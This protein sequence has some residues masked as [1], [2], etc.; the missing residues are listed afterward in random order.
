MGGVVL[1]EAG[2]Q[3]EHP[4]RKSFIAHNFGRPLESGGVRQSILA[5]NMSAIGGGLL[6]LSYA[7][8]LTGIG[9]GCFLVIVAGLASAYSI[10]ILMEQAAETGS[11]QYGELVGKKMRG[12]GTAFNIVLSAYGFGCQV[13]YSNFVGEFTS[14]LFQVMLPSVPILHRKDFVMFAILVIVIPLTVPRSISALRYVSP[15][16]VVS[17]M[18]TAV[19]IITRT[20]EKVTSN[21]VS[22]LNVWTIDWNFF[23]AL[24]NFIFAYNCHLNV[25]PV[26]SE[27]QIATDVKI[28]KITYSAVFVQMFF[29][30]C[31]ALAGYLSFGEAAR[32]DILANYAVDDPS[33]VV[34]RCALATTLTLAMPIGLN[35]TIRAFLAVFDAACEAQKDNSLETGS[36]EAELLERPKKSLFDNWIARLLSA[37]LYTISAAIM[38]C[39]V[40]D[41]SQ[42]FGLTSAVTGTLMM[43]VL[44]AVFC[45]NFRLPV[46]GLL[47][48]GALNGV[49]AVVIVLQ[50]SGV[51]PK[52][53]H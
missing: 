37:M 8:R 21:V 11:T 29:Y 20:P 43:F 45:D 34:A 39:L 4:A 28:R 30:L 31:I 47:V 9:L 23:V 18:Y 51:L 33:A 14:A 22:E 50:G 12:C 6:T 41:P 17:L 42:I 7:M 36:L 15:I 52:A 46:I 19:L 3:K 38:A 10:Q 16:S 32:S 13:A 27:L 35:P 2:A 24:G 53:P 40:G 49:G 44:P 26:A 48:L 5:L 25:V 1:A